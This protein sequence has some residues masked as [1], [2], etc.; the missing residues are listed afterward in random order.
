MVAALRNCVDCRWWKKKCGRFAAL[1]KGAMKLA[2]SGPGQ[3]LI[4][5]ISLMHAAI[6]ENADHPLGEC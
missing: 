1:I 2:C 4:I 6:W 5:G 3:V